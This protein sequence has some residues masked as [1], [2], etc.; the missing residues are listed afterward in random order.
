MADL[1]S[2][3]F[4]NLG[5]ILCS[6]GS[7]S[8]GYEL[9]KKTGLSLRYIYEVLPVLIEAGLLKEV[10]L[11]NTDGRKYVTLTPKGMTLAEVFRD[12]YYCPYSVVLL[13]LDGVI[14]KRPWDDPSD[15]LVSV[16]T[17]DLL[18]KRLGAYDDHERLKKMF[19]DKKF[20]SYSEWTQEACRVLQSKGLTRK[21]F[22][23]VIKSRRYNRGVRQTLKTLLEN[24]FT[25]GVVTGSFYELAERVKEELGLNIHIHA[26][27]RM[28]FDKKGSLVGWETYPSDYKDKATLLKI[29]E[30]KTPLKN[31]V[32]VGDDVNDI[33]IFDKVG[34]S[35]AFN[36]I[37]EKV[38]KRAKV[39]VDGDDLR[40]ILPYVM[41]RSV[42]KALLKPVSK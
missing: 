34:L 1:G 41:V 10:N 14:F 17:W 42:P 37:K 40:K 24:G 38:R 33:E 23:E 5:K 20:N 12:I 7:R 27:C 36:A 11:E 35:I 15:D 28:E 2:I 21:I 25:V 22:F 32:Y 3:K 8:H 6:I 19:I 30:K 13:D 39:I 31:V 26:H 4:E 18:F 29:I 16:S 9:H